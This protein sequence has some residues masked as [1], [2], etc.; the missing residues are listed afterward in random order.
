[1]PCH[2]HI[3]SWFCELFLQLLD[4]E[5]SRLL[6]VIE[7]CF[8]FFSVVTASK[9][10][11]LSANIFIRGCELKRDAVQKKQVSFVLCLR[12]KWDGKMVVHVEWIKQ[13]KIGL[14]LT[15]Q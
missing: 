1:M 8:L 3:M 12:K 13:M 9:C 2:W 4:R 5:I 11:S 10:A 7:N 15:A 14:G 6:L